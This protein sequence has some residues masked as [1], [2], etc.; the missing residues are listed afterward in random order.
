MLVMHATTTNKE[1]YEQLSEMPSAAVAAGNVTEC[2]S[3][4]VYRQAAYDKYCCM[5]QQL[6]PGMI[7]KVR[8]CGGDHNVSRFS[9]S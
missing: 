8:D 1:Y 7:M 9:Y 6:H 3:P 5:Q 4:A 2:R